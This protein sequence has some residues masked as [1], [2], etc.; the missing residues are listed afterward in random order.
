MPHRWLRLRP[1]LWLL[2]VLIILYGLQQLPIGQRLYLAMAPAFEVLEAPVS[3]WQQT[4][5]WF[6][7]RR[8]LQSELAETRLRLKQQASLIQEI[9]NLR[10]EN[11]QLKRLLGLE[12]IAGYRWQAAQVLARSP[13][14]VSQRLMLAISG[15]HADDVVVSSEGLVGLIDRVDATHAVVRTVLDASL[16]V[17]VTIEG[18]T[19]AALVRGQGD[20]LRVD[21]VPLKEAPP[22][23]SILQTSGAGG[24]FPAGIPVARIT[25]VQPMEGE[26]FADVKAEPTAHWGR[27]VWLA[28]ASR[29]V[30]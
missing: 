19:L 29:L 4:R 18:G 12:A 21:F 30:R 5:L 10:E 22:V 14:K 20:S 11:S 24:I 26:L 16:G 1:W 15:V 27:D 28:V 6:D 17:P 8:L 25:E 2:A 9:N 7:E 3:W 23:G 13:D